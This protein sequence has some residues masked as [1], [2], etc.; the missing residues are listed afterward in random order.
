VVE[1]DCWSEHKRGTSIA[2]GLKR[3]Q[4]I[5]IDMLIGIK[6]FESERENFI[7][8]FVLLYFFSLCVCVFFL[9]L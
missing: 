7:F 9:Y 4:V 5:Q 3:D 1:L 8:Y 6:K 2:T